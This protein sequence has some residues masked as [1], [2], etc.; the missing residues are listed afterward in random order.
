MNIIEKDI[1]KILNKI[2]FTPLKNKS[3]LITGAS[4]LLG[5]YLISC[6]KV[7]QQKYNISVYAWIK[8]KI[9]PE[10]ED[11]FNFGCTII[12]GD[13]CE[14]FSYT[15]DYIIHAAGYGQPGKFM[16]NKIK[17]IQINTEGT[18]KLFNK[19]NEGGKF[20]FMS[21]SE[22]YNGLDSFSIKE[23]QIGNTNTDN[24]RSCYIEAKRCGEAICHSFNEKGKIAKIARLSLG[25]GPGTKK[26]DHRVMNSLI[27]KA[28]KNDYI[29]LLDNGSAIRTYCYIT[30]VIEMLWNILFYSKD[31]VYNVGGKNN[32]SILELAEMI[33]KEFNKE[34][35]KPEIS[36]EMIGNPKIVN[37]SI[38]KYISEFN[39]TNFVPLKE[40][41]KNTIDWQKE[42]YKNKK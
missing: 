35:R 24:P 6:L 21:T 40:G 5:V 22:L 19:L 42:I 34:V 15:Y 25:Y 33:G 12:T 18:I 2:D 28:I 36:Q 38:E 16:D 4:G 39:K 32:V 20:L 1:E 7:I 14:D 8:N 17:T 10:F 26:G 37:I 23:N 31:T 13:I 41:L 29:E 9:Q 3:I 30:D 11:I 27:E